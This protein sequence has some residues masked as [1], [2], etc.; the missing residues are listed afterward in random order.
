MVLAILA[1]IFFFLAAANRGSRVVTS[2]VPAVPLAMVL[3]LLLGKILY[4]YF[5]LDGQEG[6]VLMGAF[7][8]CLCAALVLKVFRL[9][10][11]TGRLLDAMS[12]GGSAA[13]ALGRLACLFTSDNR[14]QMIDGT[15]GFP[16]C[17]PVTNVTS[18]EPEYRLAVFLF[19]SLAAAVLFLVLLIVDRQNAKKR[20]HRDGD[21]TLLFL[22]LYAASQIVLD[23]MRY[24]ALHL[25]SN[26]FIGA[27]Q[28][29]CAVVFAVVVGIL[30]VRLVK[31]NGFHLRDVLSIVLITACIGIAGYMEYYVQR[32]G[33]RAVFA[34]TVMAA[35]MAGASGIGIWMWRSCGCEETAEEAATTQK[36]A[37][38]R[39]ILPIISAAVVL[40]LLS[41]MLLTE[42]NMETRETASGD[43][44]LDRFF[45][46]ATNT[47][48][49]ATTQIRNTEKRYWISADADRGPKPNEDNYGRTTDP[50]V[51]RAVI[52]EAEALLDGQTLYF[53]PNTSLLADSEIRYYRDET[54]L[55]ITWKQAVGKSVYSFSE[56]KIA[57]PSQFRRYFSGGGYGSGILSY[58]TEMA[59]SVNAV[60]A[61]SGDFYSF[62]DTGVN[63]YK[64][65]VYCAETGYFDVC[66]VDKQ[67]DMRFTTR[68]EN[69]DMDSAR[70]FVEDNEILFSITFGPIL[71]QNGQ[72]NQFVSYGL[73]QIEDPYPRAAL[74]QMDSL[75][76]LVINGTAEGKQTHYLTMYEFQDFVVTTGCQNAYALDGGQT[77]AIIIDNE[78]VNRVYSGHQRKISD[79]LYFCTAL[80][81]S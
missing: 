26:G 58:P 68:H 38:A 74:C 75:H 57:D 39:W 31:K 32:N 56:V 28:L 24:D 13:I 52:Q 11:H 73:G 2:A 17:W 79:I 46:N 72:E 50:E 16:L 21:L 65:K 12:I 7:A 18:G 44:I 47:L 34:Y 45:M 42:G 70:Q 43:R 8:G 51:I 76:Y 80:P 9:E 71:V 63:V 59:S 69:F 23:S 49:D 48:Q 14:G 67:G 77:A 53:D 3:S 20:T 64:G 54:I 10:K 41:G 35:A 27:V 37:A 1:G 62:R 40:V 4:R 55:C 19:Q 78:L 66:Y 60:C 6:Y 15:P 22:L 29:V 33:G 61:T 30:L 25:H 5:H 81:N 36:H